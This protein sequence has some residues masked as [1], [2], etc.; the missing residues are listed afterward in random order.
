MSKLSAC[1]NDLGAYKLYYDEYL[2][3][4]A[5]LDCK[6]FDRYYLITLG[7]GMCNN[8]EHFL[9]MSFSNNAKIMLSSQGHQKI[10]KGSSKMQIDLKLDNSSVIYLNDANIFYANSNYTQESSIKLRN[11]KIFYSDGVLYSYANKDFLA[12]LN[13]RLYLDDELIL[14]EVFYHSKDF[15]NFIFKDYEY[16]FSLIISCDK[17]DELRT[18]IKARNSKEFK[19]GIS[20]LNDLA[21]VK[22]ACCDNDLYNDFKEELLDDFIK[23][24]A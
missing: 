15:S 2:K 10:F 18:K 3:L 22:I 14:D 13:T 19:T 12:N 21:F 4:S 16:S 6:G 8:D 17:Q 11:S 9:N 7:G 20:F 23:D 24:L 5:K 1:F